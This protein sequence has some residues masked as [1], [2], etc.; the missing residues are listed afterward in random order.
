MFSVFGFNCMFKCGDEFLFIQK[1][2]DQ[3]LYVFEGYGVQMFSE[4]VVNYDILFGV[5]IDEGLGDVWFVLCKCIDQ[6]QILVLVILIWMGQFSL[7]VKCVFECLDVVFGEIGDDGC[8]FIF[9]KVVVVGVV[10]N[11]DGVYYVIVELYQVFVDVGFIIFVG[12]LV[13]WV[14]E[15]MSSKNYV[16]FKQMFEVVVSVI[17]ILVCNVVYLVGLLYEC[18]YFV[19]GLVWEQFCCI[20]FL[21]DVWVCV[22]V[23]YWVFMCLCVMFLE[24]I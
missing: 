14:G 2:F 6:V 13:Y 23:Q 12:S 10:G 4:C 16:D 22:V 17:Q 9:G 7:V 8:Y 20:W 5:K 11:E 21:G 19:F 18:L 3:L 24:L 15:V 1:L